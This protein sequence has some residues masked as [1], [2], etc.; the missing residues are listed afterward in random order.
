MIRHAYYTNEKLMC[1][2][3]P[4]TNNIKCPDG[5]S[6]MCNNCQKLLG[7]IKLERLS[8]KFFHQEVVEQFE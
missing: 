2:K 8:K 6:I 3:T 7:L 5:E 1:G 4:D